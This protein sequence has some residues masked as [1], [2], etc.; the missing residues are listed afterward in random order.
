[1]LAVDLNCLIKD[2]EQVIV[3]RRV[4]VGEQQKVLFF[5]YKDFRFEISNF[6]N[7]DFEIEVYDPNVPA[8]TY[9]RS[10][11]INKSDYVSW[12]LWTRYASLDMECR[13]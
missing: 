13:K 11:L 7:T 10:R 3:E 5:E 6:S 9:S 2:A 4:E 1:M 8:R 12:S